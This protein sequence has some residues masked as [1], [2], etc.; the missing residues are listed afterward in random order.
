[1]RVN[2]D[3]RVV[4]VGG[5]PIEKLEESPRVT[6]GSHW[7]D[8]DLVILNIGAAAVTIRARE[9]IAAIANATNTC[10]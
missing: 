4:E 3:L 6:I 2:N 1:M 8:D 9:A 7:N 5:T 10:Q